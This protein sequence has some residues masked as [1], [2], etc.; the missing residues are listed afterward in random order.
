MI[1]KYHRSKA[2]CSTCPYTLGHVQFI[3]NPCPNCKLN[4]YTMYYVL[5]K[6]AYIEEFNKT[7]FLKSY[8]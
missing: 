1:I 3:E 6:E 8:K 7:S 4:N 2:P 5:K